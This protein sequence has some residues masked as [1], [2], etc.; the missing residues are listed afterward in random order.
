VKHDL[1]QAARNTRWAKFVGV[2]AKTLRA[3]A[4][5]FLPAARRAAS[6]RRPDLLLPKTFASGLTFLV[7]VRLVDPILF[8]TFKPPTSKRVNLCRSKPLLH[9]NTGKAI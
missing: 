8:S 7:Q 3:K 6:L 5:Q 1:A 4:Q 2:F 9:K